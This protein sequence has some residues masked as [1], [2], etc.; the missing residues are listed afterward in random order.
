MKY[1]LNGDF[2]C[3]LIDRYWNKHMMVEWHWLEFVDK[4]EY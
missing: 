3:D 1:Q 4:V 2:S